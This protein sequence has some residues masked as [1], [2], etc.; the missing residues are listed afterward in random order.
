MVSSIFAILILVVWLLL[1]IAFSWKV[2]SKPA[3]NILMGTLTYIILGI[4]YFVPFWL[5]FLK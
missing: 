2:D 4:F 5:I 3:V 1:V